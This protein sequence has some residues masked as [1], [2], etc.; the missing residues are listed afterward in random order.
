MIKTIGL[1]L[2]D[3]DWAIV[4][5]SGKREFK[6]TSHVC[7]EWAPETADSAKAEILK[8]AFLSHQLSNKNV[9]VSV[10]MKE[11]YWKQMR[12]PALTERDVNRLIK[13]AFFQGLP[14]TP[15]SFCWG[16][17]KSNFGS[18]QLLISGFAL[19]KQLMRE[20]AD[21]I[22]KAEL[23]VAYYLPDRA[24][25]STGLAFVAGEDFSTG[26]ATMFLIVNSL[27][28]EIC[29]FQANDI[30]YYRHFPLLLNEG[31]VEQEALSDELRLTK[32]M[33]RKEIRS[34]PDC[35]YL[36]DQADHWPREEGI[37]IIAAAF[38]LEQAN[39][40]I[41]SEIGLPLSFCQKKEIVS[42]SSL[43]AVG[44]TLEART[45]ERASI[46]LTTGKRRKGIK[47]QITFLLAALGLLMILAGVT[48]NLRLEHK[49]KQTLLGEIAKH[50][51]KIG[52]IKKLISLEEE[53]TKQALFFQQE[54]EMNRKM[55]KFFAVWEEVV[56]NGTILTS[57][58]FDHNEIRQITGRCLSFSELYQ[59]LL[60]SSFFKQLQAKGEIT[61]SRDG[62]EVFTLSGKWNEHYEVHN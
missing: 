26:G 17:K 58:I 60:T 59:A 43:I 36:L 4:E 2:Q 51:K 50:E 3:K 39:I 6:I 45:N 52:E 24:H 46:R 32:F 42:L 13:N 34:L 49:E 27:D 54:W 23:N 55:Q 31:K 8:K 56:P 19:P 33:I 12:L 7:G 15:D 28:V 47:D 41:P 35:C 14:G 40:K 22:Q 18:K 20:Q 10:P 29:L 61:I 21:L 25:L 9:V 1:A 53:L 30:E 11:G 38:D 5:I 16:F 48:L 44:L 62:Y 57:V 37:E